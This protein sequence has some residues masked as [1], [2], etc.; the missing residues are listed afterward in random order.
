MTSYRIAFCIAG[1]LLVGALITAIKYSPKGEWFWGKVLKGVDGEK[2]KGLV[3]KQ[4][5][6]EINII[7]ALSSAK[8]FDEQTYFLNKIQSAIQYAI[9]RHDWYERQRL[10]IFQLTLA[11]ASFM[12]VICGL[13]LEVEIIS[14]FQTGYF[15]FF[16]LFIAIVGVASALYLYNSELDGD[17]PYRSVSD[18]R[19]WYFRYNLPDHPRAKKEDSNTNQAA[20]VIKQRKTFFE[21]IAE[22]GTLDES[23]R[24][25]LEQLF[26]LQVLQR[27]KS[28]SLTRM[29]WTLVY[30]VGAF[31][32]LI[33]LSLGTVF[34]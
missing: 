24:E 20:A 21:R 15:V 28:A 9:G 7:Q 10:T 27:Y 19:F 1:L 11:A 8:S 12:F 22:Y 32:I 33:L 16:T 18:V 2:I 4:K 14:A 5:I 6:D 29:R 25:D 17:R 3:K 31:C 26:I 30:I 34:L 13:A 23:I